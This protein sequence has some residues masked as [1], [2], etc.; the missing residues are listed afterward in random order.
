MENNMNK[1]MH[2]SAM[3]E[4]TSRLILYTEGPS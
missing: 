2:N 1:Y 3:D 4:H